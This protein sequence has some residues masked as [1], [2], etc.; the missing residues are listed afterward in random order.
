MKHLLLT[1]SADISES[2][3]SRWFLIYALVFGGIVVALFMT[4]LTESRIMGFSGLSRL[5]VTYIQIT[6]AILPVFVL[7]TTVRSVAGDREAGIFEYMLSLPVSL[8]VWFWGKLIGRFIVVFLPVVLA[9]LIAVAWGAGKGAEIPWMQ[10]IY[11]TGFLVSLALCFLGIG[12]LISTLA[13]TSDVATGAAFMIWL[14]LLLFMDLILL[15]VLIREGLPSEGVIAIALTNPLQVFR[16]ASMMLFDPQLVLLGPSAYVIL[17]TF[18]HSGYIAWAL[19]YPGMLGLVCAG[20]GY[21]V[22]RRGDLP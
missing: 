21:L 10:V 3:R 1:A 2:L 18:G 9:M 6:M 19:L 12:M 4:G 15:G 17:D 20:L 22:F 8:S 16:T 7:I 5:L 14:V 13:R 11:Y